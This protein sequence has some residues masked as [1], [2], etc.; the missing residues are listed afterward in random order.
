MTYT[1][2][3]GRRE[4]LAE[5]ADAMG[6]AYKDSDDAMVIAK[7]ISDVLVAFMKELGVVSIKDMG[8]TLEDCLKSADL[9][10]YDAA[11]ANA[12]GKPSVE[13]AREYIKD[14]YFIYQ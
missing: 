6:V 5:T 14:T 7:A 11:F 8:Y 13:E 4:D 9:F 2:K 3:Y 12:P 1:A 10:Q